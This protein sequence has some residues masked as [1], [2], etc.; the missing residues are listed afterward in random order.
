MGSQHRSRY[1][2]Y[3]ELIEQ[4]GMTQV[5]AA[6]WLDVGERTSRRWATDEIDVPLGVIMLLEVMAKFGIDPHTARTLAGSPDKRT[7]YSD[8]RRGD[9]ST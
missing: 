4:L 2:R 5:G 8:Q 3:R 6:K 7:D 1:K 9:E